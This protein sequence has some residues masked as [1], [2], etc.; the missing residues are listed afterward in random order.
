MIDPKS[1]YKKF[2]DFYDLYVGKFNADLGFYE[3]FLT[4]DNTI[5][6][7]GC[8][9]GR[10]LEYFAGKQY[11]MAG[12]D[13]S[14]EMLEKAKDKL[15]SLIDSGYVQLINHDFTSNCLPHKFNHAL[16]TFYTFNYILDKPVEFLKNIKNSMN[17]NGALLMDV[18]YPNS[19]YDKSIDDQWIEKNYVVEG[20]KL[21]ILDKRHME[22][23]IEHRKQIFYLEGDKTEIETQR[24]YYP[25][26]ELLTYLKEAGFKDIVLAPEYL[27]ELFD[28]KI[29]MK[30]VKTNYILK[31]E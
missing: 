21:K 15:K 26:D 19:L 18:F 14:R 1:T 4:Q 10:I 11:K 3:H 17:E 2:A 20:Q 29:E 5:V 6:E 12:V 31:A 13:I 27:Y 23:D 8:G 9:T 7:I 28:H 16:L 25:P 30:N 24:R 22:G